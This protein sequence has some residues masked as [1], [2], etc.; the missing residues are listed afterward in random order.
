MDVKALKSSFASEKAMKSVN[1]QQVILDDIWCVT[2]DDF[3]IDD[4]FDI[5]NEENMNDVD[6]NNSNSNNN[7]NDG[8]FYL[9]EEQEDEEEEEEKY[10]NSSYSLSSSHDLVDDSAHFSPHLGIPDDDMQELELWSH[11]MD[12][13]IPEPSLPIPKSSLDANFDQT[14]FT[15]VNRVEPWPKQSVVSV[16]RFPTTVPVKKRSKRARST[17]NRAWFTGDQPKTESSLSLE[18]TSLFALSPVHE[19]SLLYTFGEPVM[20]KPRNETTLVNGGIVSVQRRCSH[21]QVTKTPQWRA[22]P[23]GPKTLCNACGVRFKS[24]RLFPEYRP[25]CSP[26]F[27]SEVHSNS[28]RKV[29]EM[30]HKR[31]MV[32]VKSHT[33]SA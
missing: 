31:E 6:N 3:V 33:G 26:T 16:S 13:S 19:M 28:H 5:P 27:S 23:D 32:E 15:I 22:G 8:G 1:N 10:S 21:C 18:S 29:L 20:K 9:E 4:F 25:A 30:R 17:K 12:D 24:G 2:G 14:G 7:N 11:F